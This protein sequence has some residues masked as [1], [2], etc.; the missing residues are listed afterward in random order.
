MTFPYHSSQFLCLSGNQTIVLMI[1][2]GNQTIVLM[3]QHGALCDSKSFFF[4]FK[5]LL[6]TQ[7]YHDVANI[8]V[9]APDF[10]YSMDN[11]VHPHVEQPTI[12]S[13]DVLDHPQL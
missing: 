7:Q 10:N 1:L 11:L 13:F 6:L 5:K 3:I 2:S 9:I 12:S 4:L 8:L